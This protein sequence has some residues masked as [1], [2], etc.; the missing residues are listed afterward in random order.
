MDP[1]RILYFVM[2]LYMFIYDSPLRA[3]I[4][5]PKKRWPHFETF[6][7]YYD[8]CSIS[9]VYMLSK[10]NTANGRNPD[11]LGRTVAGVDVL[12]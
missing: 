10:I 3:F 2:F 7:K 12:Y 11:D 8:G 5:V 4:Y 9:K 6:A 1:G